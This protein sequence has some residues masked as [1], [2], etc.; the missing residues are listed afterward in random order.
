MYTAPVR[1]E[2]RWSEDCTMVP[3]LR[4]LRN[5]FALHQFNNKAQ[6]TCG[7]RIIFF[8]G[9]RIVHQR[10]SL[11]DSLC[12]LSLC[13]FHMEPLCHH[14][15]NHYSICHYAIFTH[16]IT[17]PFSLMDSLCHLSLCHFHMEPLCHHTWS[18]DCTAASNFTHGTTMPFVIMPFSLIESLCHLRIVQQRVISLME[19]LCHLSLCHFH[20]SNHYAIWGLYT[21]E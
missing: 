14:T 6:H 9:L 19:P 8:C 1:D 7:L 2:V 5:T 10:T 13:H 3:L 17:M 20:S 18:E 21:S 12:H 15:W 16:R 4:E 11:M